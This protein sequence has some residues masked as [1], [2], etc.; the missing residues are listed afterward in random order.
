MTTVHLIAALLLVPSLL[1][2]ILLVL[3]GAASRR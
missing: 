1:A 3:F 2:L